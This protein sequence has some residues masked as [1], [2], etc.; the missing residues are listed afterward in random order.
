M[1]VKASKN[2][3]SNKRTYRKHK[4]H[5]EDM[6]YENELEAFLNDIKNNT[7]NAEQFEENLDKKS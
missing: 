7:P 6:S 4:E 2:S 5:A 1:V 3:S